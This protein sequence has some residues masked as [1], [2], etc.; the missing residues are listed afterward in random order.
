MGL[1]M[2][3]LVT[4]S[5]GF[6]GRHMVAEL[7]G[8]G[9]E[10]DLCDPLHKETEVPYYE[11]AHMVFRQEKDE[12]SVYD[13]VVHCAAAAPYRAAIDGQP[14]NLVAD[15]ALDTALF[16]WAVRTEQKHV[17]YISSSAAYPV[18]LQR[19]G[20][21]THLAED[22]IDPSRPELGDAAYGLTKLTGEQMAGAARAA[23][24]KVTVVRPFSGYGEDQGENWP[25]GAFIGRALRREDPFTIWGDSTQVRDWIHIDDVVR[26]MYALYEQGVEEPVNLCTGVGTSMLKLVTK[27]CAASG[28]Y[29]EI[30]VDTEAPQG[31]HYRV[32]NPWRL[33]QYYTPEI[34]V[35]EG[36]TRALAAQSKGEVTARGV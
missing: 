9:W 28:Y 29:P 17:V 30:V 24:V 27:I 35:D 26:A 20:V 15:L 1:A 13:L 12:G 14:M 5:A 7:Q 34:S 33:R 23:G 16:K 2:K 3:A 10:V 8:R 11:D 18:T 31:V 6:V 22:V 25:F 4:G 21:R 19:K 32:G 36:I